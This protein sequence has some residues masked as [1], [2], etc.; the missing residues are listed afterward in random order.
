M[1]SA[2][3]LRSIPEESNTV[4]EIREVH[5]KCR[6]SI[7]NILGIITAIITSIILS[8]TLVKFVLLVTSDTKAQAIGELDKAI[9][10]LDKIKSSVLL[11]QPTSSNSKPI[12]IPKAELSNGS[13]I[14]SEIEKDLRGS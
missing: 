13:N 11:I 9:A 3:P 10:S 7:K 5:P 8:F 6:F 2:I 14:R 12:E 1:E 4:I